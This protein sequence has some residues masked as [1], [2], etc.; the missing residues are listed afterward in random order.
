MV[1]SGWDHIVAAVTRCLD[2]E[3]SEVRGLKEKYGTLRMDIRPNTTYTIALEDLAEEISE[4]TCES[5]GNRGTMRNVRG[6][7]KVRCEPCF[8]VEEGE[9]AKRKGN[10]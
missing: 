5:C 10:V 4:V 6:W 1:G 8:S 7:Y 2:S 3:Q 9:D